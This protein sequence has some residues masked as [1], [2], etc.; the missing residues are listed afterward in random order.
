MP[1][2]ALLVL[3]RVPAYLVVGALAALMVLPFY[4]MVVT[5]LFGLFAGYAFAVYRF[6]L[7][8]AFFLMILATLMVPVQVTSVALYVLLA[9]LRRGDTYLVHLAPD[10]AR[11]FRGFVM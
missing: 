5:A 8:N 3:A 1:R 9:R 4:W 7:Q 6:P 11:A 10:V 2:S